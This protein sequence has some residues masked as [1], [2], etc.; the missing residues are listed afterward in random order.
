MPD[1]NGNGN[2]RR[3]RRSSRVTLRVAMRVYE[4]G[5]SKRFA[6]EE[7]HSVKVSL[8]GGLVALKTAVNLSQKLVVVNR[9]TSETREARVVSVGPLQLSQRLVGFEFLEPSPKFW[10]V[11]FP[12]AGAQRIPAR[13]VYRSRLS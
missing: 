3:P 2:A 11:V 10:G 7:T 12:P 4:A 5:T 13:S 8:W 9:A 6:I 1:G